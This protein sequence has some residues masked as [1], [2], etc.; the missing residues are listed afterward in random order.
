MVNFH[1][2]IADNVGRPVKVDVIH[3]IG[4][5]GVIMP[6]VAGHSAGQIVN[7][8]DTVVIYSL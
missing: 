6:A 5:R 7:Q 1:R 8:L 4:N 2:A 3:F